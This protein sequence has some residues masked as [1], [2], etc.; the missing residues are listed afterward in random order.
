M[1]TPCL[2]HLEPIRWRRLCYRAAALLFLPL[3]FL[4]IIFPEVAQAQSLKAAYGFEEPSGSAVTDASGF[5]NTGTIMGASR[6]A[7][8]YGNALLFNGTSALVSIPDAAS[9]HLSNTMTLEAWVYPNSITGSWT[10]VIMKRNDDYYLEASSTTG[11]VSAVGGSFATT[12]FGTTALPVG[13]WSHLAATYDGTT[14]RLYVNGVQVNS[15]PQTGTMALSGGPLSL[16][17]DSQ[18][19]QYFSGR[20]DEVRVYDRALSPTEI[21]ADMATPITATGSDTTPPTVS[22]TPLSATNVGGVI[23]VGVQASDNSGVAY[24]NLLVDGVSVGTDVTTPYF[25]NWNTNTTSNGSHTLSAEAYDAAGNRGVS[26][27]IPITVQNPAFVNEVV[28]PDITSATTIAFLPDGRMLVGELTENIWVVH[29]GSSTRQPTPFAQLL[30]NT[31][32]I[33]EQGLMDI[34]LDPAFA[35]NNWYYVFYTHTSSSV[36]NVDRVSRF[37]ASGDGTVPG[38]E[39]IIWQD[40]VVAQAEHHGGCIFFGPG[41]K[42]FITVGDHFVSGDAQRLDTFHGKLLRVNPDGTVPTDNPFYD[43]AG[44][45]RDAIWAYGL[46]NPFRACYD[47][48]SNRIFIGDVGGNDPATAKEEVNIGAKG[49]NYGWPLC[50]GACNTTGITDPI[51]FYPHLGRDAAITGGFVYRGG[52]YPSDYQGSYFFG[53]Y[54]QNW[55]KRLTFDSSG[56]LQGVVEFEPAD[57]TPDGPTGDPVYFL[58]GLDGSLWY[59]DIG[60]NDQHVP[61]AAAIRRLR[62]L[63]NNLPPV[64]VASANQ[65]VG[66]APLTV[67]FS[68]AGSMDPDGTTLTYSWDFGD[69]TTSTA[70]N[71]THIYQFN[72]SYSARL[73]VSDGSS[74]ALSNTITITVGTPPTV[75]ILSP[76]SG[77]LFIAGDVIT[78][79]GSAFDSAGVALPASA[80]SWTILFHHD[81]HIHPGGGPFSGVSG[82]FTVPVTGHDF[83]GATSYEFIL[84][85]TGPNG[86]ST[87]KSVTV[88]PDKVNLTFTTLPP[89]LSVDVGGIRHVTPFILDT[90]KSFQYTINAPLQTLSGQS[91]DFVSWSDGGARSHDIITPTTDASWIATFSAVGITGLKAAYGFEE[92]SGTSTADRSGL[93]N[94]GTLVGG[95]AWTTAGR[96][97]RAVTFNGTNAMVTVPDA[98]SLHLTT[99]MT[100]EA[101][102]YPNSVTGAWRDVIM[103]QNDDFYIE[104]TSPSSLPALGS[105]FTTP[106]YG[107]TSLLAAAWTHVA[108]TYDGATLKFYVNGTQVGSRAQTGSL[109]LSGGPLSFGGDAQWGQYFS[110]RIDEVRIYDRA[111]SVSEIQADM[112]TAILTGVED[113]DGSPPLASALLGASPNPFSPNTRIRYRLASAQNATLR[114]FDVAGRLIRSLDSQPLLAGVHEIGWDGTDGRGRRAATGVY[115]ARLNAPDRSQSMRIILVR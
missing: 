1:A 6:I 97:G 105:S 83:S 28:V 46:R 35:T 98:T 48:L 43:G 82:T 86:L 94:T 55:I 17:G 61:N 2:S 27:T 32:L 112:S 110:G 74:T 33:G 79:S 36:G 68:S 85:A 52:N 63:T 16:G 8:R 76:V 91:Y 111:L 88:F 99:A 92:G 14:M 29:A 21:Q 26:A 11:S 87:S 7:G 19:G 75:N 53:D 42:L 66:Q 38:S 50:E 77:S 96:F 51:Y 101:W 107:V 73:Q 5:Q 106:L 58:Q 39:V 37:T 89:G 47:S 84:T 24:V 45:N 102:V 56:N 70:P 30:G 72:G 34:I 57:G 13:A 104:A 78:Y 20:I 49:A 65:T 114:I 4:L 25:V 109:P 90:A 67:V 62:R 44:P 93:G 41:G 100:L 18:F 115:I 15:Q 81:S 108:A 31:A 12:L 22:I 40:D 103:K 80:Y 23:Q 71:P 95:A 10:D 113:H 69:N 9:L 3:A 54:V 60:F 59:V 64:A